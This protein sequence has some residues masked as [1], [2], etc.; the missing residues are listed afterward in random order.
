MDR[1]SFTAESPGKPIKLKRGKWAFSPDPLS[2]SINADWEIASRLSETRQ[3]IGRL[4]GYWPTTTPLQRAIGN[5]LRFQEAKGAL[6]LERLEADPVLHFLSSIVSADESKTSRLDSISSFLQAHEA[7]LEYLK[8]DFPPSIDLILKLYSTIFQ[9]DSSASDQAGLRGDMVADMGLLQRIG[10]DFQYIPPPENQ[11][12]MAL[13][14]L[15]KRFRRPASHPDLVDFALVFY[16]MIAIQPFDRGNI[17]TTCLLNNIMI[18]NLLPFNIPSA[19]ISPFIRSEADGFSEAFMRVVRSGDWGGWISFFLK[20]LARQFDNACNAAER[21]VNL[22][23]EYHK[24]LEKERFSAP[25]A[26]LVDDLFMTP[27]ITVN[28]ASRLARVTFR[29]AQ[30]NIDK[31]AGLDILRETTGQKRNRVY[32][33]PEIINIYEKT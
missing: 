8:K 31:L 32:I 11:L 14:S 25:L 22:R 7:G 1:A 26:Q 29:A 2:S 13:Y 20:G 28:H 18:S 9:I 16:Q 23:S 3:S 5:I 6:E 24:R 30:F 33:A 21:A 12:K 4:E 10:V 27:V 15:D 17:A 19:P